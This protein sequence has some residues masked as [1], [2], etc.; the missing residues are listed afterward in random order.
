MDLDDIEILKLRFVGKATF[1]KIGIKYGN[2]RQ[3]AFQRVNDILDK[4]FYALNVSK[5]E[6]K[7]GIGSH[8]EELQNLIFIMGTKYTDKIT[9]LITALGI[10]SPSDF[11]KYRHNDLMGIRGLGERFFLSLKL[12]LLKMD[13]RYDADDF[14]DIM[15]KLMKLKEYNSNGIR[16]RFNI[17]KRDGFRCHYCGRSPHKDPDVV[18]HVDHI[19]PLSKGGSWDDSNL[20]TSCKECNVGKKDIELSD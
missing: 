19:K 7:A 16:L 8:S 15:N 12:A 2:T 14:Q 11:S 17:L 13:Y 3:W 18:L 6:E 4:L 5:W 9:R 20:I 10:D 1:E